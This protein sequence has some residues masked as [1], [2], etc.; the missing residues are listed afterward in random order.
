MEEKIVVQIEGGSREST[1]WTCDDIRLGHTRSRCAVNTTFSASSQSD[2]VRLHFG[3]RGDYRFTY[4][5]LG[6]TF[7]LIGSHHN[8]MYSQGFDMTVQNKTA[9]IETFGIQF[10]K[11]T[12]IA[13][14]QNTTPELEK[15]SNDVL[16]GRSVM[17][18]PHWGAID[19]GIQTAIQQILHNAYTGDVKKMF[20]LSKSVE[21]LVLSAEACTKPVV[22]G[23]PFLKSKTDK[24]KII[25]VRD[26]VNARAHCPPNLSEIARAVGLNEYKL[27]RGFKEIFDTTVFGYLTAQRLH[28]AERYLRDTRKTAAEISSELG[29]ATPQHFNNAF[30]K[31]FGM[32]PFAVRK[33][34]EN[35][36]R[37]T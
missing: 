34:P 4:Q 20:L 36:I 26:L 25:A 8:L 2:V 21:L 35:A 13:Y 9:E 14:T 11:D 18:S 23:E 27:K 12:F 30:K 37:E 7:D 32:T 29:Y 19:P 10:P 17:L 6:Q 33:N 22:R 24:E 28:L 15:F 1:V 3:M 31:K 5:Q 16:A